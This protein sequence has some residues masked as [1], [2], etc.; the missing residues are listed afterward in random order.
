M[1]EEE[2]MKTGDPKTLLIQLSIPAICAQIVTLLYNTVDRVYIGRMADGTMAMAGIG[3]CMPITMVL[4]GLSALF[5]RGGS[6]LAAISLGKE[7]REEAELFLGNSF[8][9]LVITSLSVMA[10]TL[11]FQNPLLKMFG[12]SENTMGYAGDYLTIYLYGT[13]FVQITV[14]MNY[15]ITTQGF[16]KTAMVTTMLG[17]V[18]NI[19]LDPVFMF[20]MG[21]GIKGAA[22]ATVVSQMI[23]CIF[24]LWF[25][26]GKNTKLRLRL[27]TM[28]IDKTVITRVLILGASPFFM[29]TSEGVMHICF[30]MQVLKYG[31][32]LAVGA[33]TI[34]FSMFQFI[35]LPLTGISQGSQPIVSFNYGARDYGRVRQTLQLATVACTLF[36]LCG[37]T[38]MM[39]FP[40]FFIRLF[41]RDPQLVELGARMLR[42]YISGCFFIGANSL[43]QQTYTSMGEGKMSFFFAFFRKVI[44][45]IPL[46]YIFPVVFPWGVLAVALAEPVSDLLTTLC[47]K[48]YFRRF[49]Q[50]KLKE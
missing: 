2:R 15:F 26:T 14:G 23:S 24:V 11:I 31:G 13:L 47:N 21:M 20:R 6:P 40:A 38:L 8:I 50:R 29:S 3:L 10:A 16:A 42:V 27:R 28:R 18:L 7:D 46:L 1:I 30:N 43:Y 34:L 4:S 12:A 44:L 17:A 22:L 45:L 39:L 32:D 25:L 36:S 5:G 9:S 35:N 33:M 37:T 49:L 19:I 41:N 48:I